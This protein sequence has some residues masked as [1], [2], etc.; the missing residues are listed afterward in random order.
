MGMVYEKGRT[1]LQKNIIIVLS[2]PSESGNVGAVCRVMK[3]MGLSRLRIVAPEMPLDSSLIISR[4]VH[5][6]D[7]WEQAEH[8]EN[9]KDALADCSLVVGTTRRLGEKRKNISL[10]PKETAAYIMGKGGKTAV[11]FGNERTGLEKEEIDLCSMASHIPASDA[12]PSLNLSHA[13]QI[14]A[15]EFFLASAEE[16]SSRWVPADR[17]AL[18]FMVQVMSNSLASIGFYKQYGREDQEHFFR[19]IFSRAGTTL[20]EARYLE[21]LFKKIAILGRGK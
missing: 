7:V 10:S 2:R 5:A 6:G 21:Q 16:K 3:N 15:Y 12:F 8:F 14:Y 9:L 4:A 19:D 20:K 18:D 13:V 17:T 11:V 1:M